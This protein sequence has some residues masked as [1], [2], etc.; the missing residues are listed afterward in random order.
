MDNPSS[1]SEIAISVSDLR[2]TFGKGDKKVE[3]VR[4]ISLSVKKGEIFGFL[5]PNGA[6]KTTSLRMIVGLLTPT[7]GEVKI[8]GQD[9]E[10]NREQF[11]KRIGIIPQE[12]SLYNEL[13]VEENLWFIADA[14]RIPKNVAKER[15]D[16]LISRIGLDEKR[17]SLVKTLSGGLKRRLNLILG[18]VHNPEIILCDEPTP[19]LDPQ[20][21][22]AV[23]DFLKNLPNEG[24]TVIL[25]THF[26]EEADRLSNRIAII[27][28]GEILVIDTPKKLKASVGEGDLVEFELK[29]N[30]EKYLETIKE[31]LKGFN[32]IEDS[33][34]SNERIVIRA[35]D[36]I[37]KLSN[38]LNYIEDQGGIVENMSIRN[39]TLEDVFINLTGRALRD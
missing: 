35:L 29:A 3:A 18:L 23:W 7:E 33:Y 1:S 14:Y 13:T 6:G 34:I 17:Q 16:D 28:H 22:L 11:K 39:T 12:I 20:S 5:G 2:K 30:G 25:T 9:P 15:I 24:K 27:D 19:G 10:K 21:R 8:F 26:M 36:V 31:K 37:P 32:G 38:I 4:G